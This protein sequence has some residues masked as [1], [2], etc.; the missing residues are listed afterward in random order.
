M[1]S[2][3]GEDGVEDDG[4]HREGKREDEGLDALRKDGVAAV[5]ND[6]I[7]ETGKEKEEVD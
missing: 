1:V 3:S 7:N 4:L 5:E 6:D 2:R